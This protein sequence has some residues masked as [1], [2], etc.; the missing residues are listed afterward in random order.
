MSYI[1]LTLARNE[2]NYLPKVAEC[3][4][5]Q[6]SLPSLWLIV[7]DGSTDKTQTIID[8]LTCKHEWIIGMKL[9]SGP[10]GLGLHFARVA[11]RGFEELQNQAAIRKKSY[12]FIGKVDADVMF[13]PE[14]FETL[15]CEFEDESLGIVSSILIQE[16]GSNIAP[17]EKRDITFADYPTDGVRI[18]R[19]E[20]F[21][22]VGGIHVVKAPEV[23]V[24]VKARVKGWKLKRV[25]KVVA[26]H[27]RKSH[28]ETSLWRRWEMRGAEQHY[29]G[30]H[31][32]V[33]L[34]SCFYDFLYIRPVY[35][36]L[37][38]FW[39][40]MKSVL[41]KADKI[42]DQEVLQYFRNRYSKEITSR[43]LSLYRVKR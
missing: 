7:N 36:A 2:E 15:L 35:L 6:T 32:L 21:E 1:L 28:Q 31:P 3:V 19:R 23:V 16:D 22:Q 24:G 34:G 39:G 13:G 20:C 37:A 9:P 18:Y 40:Y 8:E 14:C 33:V 27:R 5:K 29:L 10:G 38:H 42:P 12:Q 4:I 41:S 11:K 17:K 25:D 43:V 26:F 30:Y